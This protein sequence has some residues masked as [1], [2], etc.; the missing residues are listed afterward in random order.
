MLGFIFSMLWPLWL[1]QG[2][3]AG[4][5]GLMAKLQWGAWAALEQVV[6]LSEGVA[7]D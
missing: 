5:S 2:P 4:P 7:L 1:V 6:T 3:V